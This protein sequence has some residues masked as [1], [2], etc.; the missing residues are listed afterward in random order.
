[1]WNTLRARCHVTSYTRWRSGSGL[2]GGGWEGGLGTRGFA[3]WRVVVY[4]YVY[5]HVS[6]SDASDCDWTR[7]KMKMI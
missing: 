3:M 4:V 2:G 5:I 6:L 1:M 7:M